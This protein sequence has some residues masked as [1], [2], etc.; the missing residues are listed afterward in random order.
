MAPL[1]KFTSQSMANQKRFLAVMHR[2]PPQHHGSKRGK[3]MSFV[4]TRELSTPLCSPRLK[5]RVR[6]KVRLLDLRPFNCERRPPDYKPHC[7]LTSEWRKT[8]AEPA[9]PIHFVASPH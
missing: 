1:G 6:N 9:D 3:C 5:S 4:S 2:D 8:H 7:L